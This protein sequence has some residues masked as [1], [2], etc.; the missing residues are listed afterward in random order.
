[1]NEKTHSLRRIAVQALLTAVSCMPAAAVLADTLDG[2]T[3]GADVSSATSQL[4]AMA[5]H[6]EH[7]EGVPRDYEKAAALYCKAARLGDADAQYA[8]GWMYANGRGVARDDAVAAQIFSL[9]ADRGHPAAKVMRGYT[10]T[11]TSAVPAPL[12]ACLLPDPP[13]QLSLIAPDITG[14]AMSETYFKGPI[15]KLVTK[16]ADKSGIDPKLVMAVIL[17]ESGFNPRAQSPKNAQGLMQLIPETAQRFQVKDAFD[18]EQNIKGGIAYLKWLLAYFKG[19]VSLVAAAY[20]AGE[21]T[22]DKYRGV[23]P[24]PETQK[25][26][27]RIAQLYQKAVHPY[28]SRLMEAP[29]ART[30]ATGIRS[31]P[32]VLPKQPAAV[33]RVMTLN[34]GRGSIRID[35][36]AVGS[37]QPVG[38]DLPAASSAR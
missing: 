32:L 8:L 11:A 18:P 14:P 21:G 12:P 9:A 13:S 6:Y 38:F 37:V 36:T 2:A 23:P 20:N 3:N 31:A 27:R 25:Y 17:V 10:A 1:M 30:Q 34:Q 33:P 7:A 24:Y 5:T 26:V 22:V 35:G 15:Y 4:V 19:D 28:E 16:L 29:S